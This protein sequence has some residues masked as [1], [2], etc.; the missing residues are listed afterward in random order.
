[1]FVV[2]MPLHLVVS[3]LLPGLVTTKA[4]VVSTQ[5]SKWLCSIVKCYKVAW[6]TAELGCIILFTS[7]SLSLSVALSLI[8]TL[9]DLISFSYFQVATCLV[10]H[11]KSQFSPGGKAWDVANFLTWNCTSVLCLENV[12]NVCHRG[13]KIIP[14]AHIDATVVLAWA[15]HNWI[16]KVCLVDE[17]LANRSP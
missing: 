11:G 2:G 6:I 14:P 12:T 4:P 17:N 7:L 5:I 10:T 13:I 8:R 15:A 16:L 9:K 3:D 1:M